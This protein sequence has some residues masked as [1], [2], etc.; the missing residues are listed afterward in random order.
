MSEYDD[1]DIREC[2]ADW[3]AGIVAE[4]IDGVDVWIWRN[5]EMNGAMGSY[6]FVNDPALS[7]S[8]KEGLRD[9]A[10]N[11]LEMWR[12]NRR[13]R[14]ERAQRWQMEDQQKAFPA[15][16]LRYSNPGSPGQ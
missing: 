1:Q 3:D 15:R 11:A 13:W 9:I 5:A 8:N 10:W 12:I 14:A 4:V 6:R 2:P 7:M 16:A